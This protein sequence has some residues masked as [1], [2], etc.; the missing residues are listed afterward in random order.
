MGHRVDGAV[1]LAVF[2]ELREP[3]AERIDLRTLVIGGR[4]AMDQGSPTFWR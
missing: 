1:D 3:R 4:G 2:S